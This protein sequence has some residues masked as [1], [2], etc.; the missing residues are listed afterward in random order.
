LLPKGPLQNKV[1]PKTKKLTIAIKK[2]TSHESID[3]SQKG[4]KEEDNDLK[5]S[6]SVK[7]ILKK[8]KK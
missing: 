6:K 3:L 4:K 1:N 7:S 5:S 8:K 2:S